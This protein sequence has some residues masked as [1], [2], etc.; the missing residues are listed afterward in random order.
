ML[1]ILL[2][3]PHKAKTLLKENTALLQEDEGHLFGKKFRLHIIEIK[4][5]KKKSLEVLWVIMI[6]ILPCQKAIYLTK[7]DHKV[8]RD[9]ITRQNQ[10]IETKSKI[11]DFKTTWVQVPESSTMQV[12]HQMVNTSFIIQKEVPLTSNSELVPLIKIATLEH[13]HPIIRKLF[14]KTI[15]NVPLAGGLA[16]FI[17]AWEKITRVQE[18]LSIVK[19]YEIPFVSLLFQEKI[20]NLAK[21]SKKQFSLVEQE[22]LEMLEKGAI[23]K[24]TRAIFE[25]PKQGQFLSHLILVEEKDGGNRPVINLKNLSKFIHSLRAFRNGRCALSKIHSRTGR[26]P[27]EDRSQG[28]IFFS[29]PQQE[30]SKVCQISKVRQHIRISLLFFWTRAS[31]KN[32]Y[33]IIKSPNCLLETGQHSNHYLSRRYVANGEDVIKNSHG[34]THVDFSIAIFGFCD[35]PQKNQS[36][37]L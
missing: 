21:M 5:S 20:P 12:Q 13:V 14:T 33:K 2:K 17:A 30:L 26:F 22:V 16:Y 35:Q 19:G 11:F 3:D 32:F 31:S 27:M 29:S 1:K 24:V 23:Q 8:E 34:K 6:K 9:T 36:C 15:P 28:G 10:V 25:P 4:R 7:I 37:T 18:I